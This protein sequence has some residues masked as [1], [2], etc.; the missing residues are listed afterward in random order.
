M[1]VEKQITLLEFIVEAESSL[2][3]EHVIIG[4][5]SILMTKVGDQGLNLIKH[6]SND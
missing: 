4:E 3:V 2:N 1:F 6:R 5:D